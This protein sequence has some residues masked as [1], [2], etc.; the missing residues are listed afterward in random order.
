[1]LEIGILLLLILLNGFF[2]ISEI[3]LVSVK[4]QKIENKAKKG[5]KKA[6]T[7][8]SLLEKPEDFLS[9]IQVGI[10]LIGIISGAYGGATLVK[11]LSPFFEQFS[12]IQAHASELSYLIIIAAITYFSIVWG[13]LIPK[14]FGMRNPE[15]IALFVAPVIKV[16][17]T[18]VFPFVKILSFS[19]HLCNKI[20][21]ISDV[22]GEKISEDELIYMLKT[23][24]LQGVLEKEESELHQNVF[25]FSEQK[26]KSLMTYRKKVEWINLKSNFSDIEKQ[27]KESNF[28]KFPVCDGNL[29]EANAYLAIKEFYENVNTPDF[30]IKSILK[31]PIFIPENM[32]SV[33]IL[34]EF[35]ENKQHMGFVVDEYGT[36][37]GI[38]TLQDLIEGIVGDMPES[39]EEE[40]EIIKRTDDSYLVNGNISIRDL[41]SFFDDVVIELDDDEYVTLAGFII[42]HMEYIPEV[43]EKFNHNGFTFEIMD[44]DSNRIDKVLMTRLEEKKE[45]KEKKPDA[46]EDKE[47]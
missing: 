14:T 15:K 23:A 1:M 34:Q 29:D 13:E 38:I 17:S 5:N 9:S 4:R 41:N 16:F 44:K 24:S 46:E 40:T 12:S 25:A 32:H 21:K 11:Y 20:F 28:T 3:S 2:A 6:Q 35:R 42:F 43:A 47:P 22:E 8:L 7:V 27:I 26:A 37:Q 31:T 10:T 30:D 45:K 19:T 18:A 36:F 33:D 39:D